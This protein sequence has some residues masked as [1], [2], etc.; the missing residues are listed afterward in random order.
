MLQKRTPGAPLSE[1]ELEQRRAAARAR[2]ENASAGAAG[3]ALAAGGLATAFGAWRRNTASAELQAGKVRAE[4]KLRG[5]EAAV[6]AHAGKMRDLDQSLSRPFPLR[7]YARHLSRK[8]GELDRR[9]EDFE[10]GRGKLPDPRK[11]FAEVREGFAR[12][13]ERMFT[14][15]MAAQRAKP[16]KGKQFIAGSGKTRVPQRLQG[17]KEERVLDGWFDAVSAGRRTPLVF[18]TAPDIEEMRREIRADLP[19][20]QAAFAAGIRARGER[21]A[22]RARAEG[23]GAARGVLRRFPAMTRGRVAAIAG[24]GALAGAGASWGR[25]GQVEKL[26]K[27][28]TWRTLRAAMRSS[29]LRASERG[30]KEQLASTAAGMR[31]DWAARQYGSATPGVTWTA[32]VKRAAGDALT[33]REAAAAD[34]LRAFAQER[35][36][37]FRALFRGIPYHAVAKNK[38]PTTPG[39]IYETKHV[40]SA[41]RRPSTTSQFIN[42]RPDE[43]LLVFRGGR[44]ARLRGAIKQDRGL[45]GHEDEVVLPPGKWRVDRVQMA[46]APPVRF[47]GKTYRTD[48]SSPVQRI[49]L[50]PVEKLAK[51]TR[52]APVR[53]ALE[54]DAL[55]ADARGPRNAAEAEVGTYR[56]AH[57]RLHGL[58]IAI[59]TPRGRERIGWAKDG[60]VKW[61]AVM[62]AHYGYVKGTVGA[63]GDHVDVYLMPE[64]MDPTRPVFV[65][66]Q[67]KL[68]SRAFDEVKVILGAADEAEALKVYDAGFNDGSGPQRRRATL[69]MSL[70]EFKDWLKG[71]TGGLAKAVSPVLARWARRSKVNPGAIAALYPR[72]VTERMLP[73]GSPL[74]AVTL[75][76]QGNRRAVLAQH[77]QSA[78]RAN[79][80]M[81]GRV[82]RH[83]LWHAADLPR[84][85]PLGE[86]GP[87]VAAWRRDRWIPPHAAGP[88]YPTDTAR[89]GEALAEVFSVVAGRDS[90]SRK[91]AA[92]IGA[93]YPVLT[94]AVRREA[95][96]HGFLHKAAPLA[97]VEPTEPTEP[98]DDGAWGRVEPDDDAPFTPVTAP[99][100]ATEDTIAAALARLFRGWLRNPRDVGNP[101]TVAEALRPVQDAFKAG[102]TVPPGG[103]QAV[104]TAGGSGRGNT[105][106]VSFDARNPRVEQHLREYSLG[107]IREISD[108]SRQAIRGALTAASIS[109]APVEQ[110]ARWIRESIGLTDAQAGWVRSFRWQLE[111]LD[112]RALGRE[113][114]DKRF[115]RTIQRAIETGTPIPPEKIDQM[116]EAYQR[117]TLAYRATTIARTE[118]I[119]AANLGSLASVRAMLDAHPELTVEKIWIATKDDRTRD[120]H[121]QLDGKVVEGLDAPFLVTNAKGEQVAIRWPHDPTAPAE[122]LIN[123]RCT[124]GF[125]VKPRQAVRFVAEAA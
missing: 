96:R 54:L 100:Q 48:R 71:Q 120:T 75:H 64:A 9:W 114:R 121:R 85:R 76:Q 74:A 19:K 31:P 99:T 20:H 42:A 84:Q 51:R 77:G 88:E 80:P 32:N 119:R 124:L 18:P 35:A 105:L 66:E 57:L 29:G 103:V 101:D 97:K 37:P 109:G 123:C 70:P 6:T 50:S 63:D 92:R 107:L 15:R 7:A 125:R 17:A 44:G 8:I 49:Y 36:R 81:A 118:A 41:T 25:A 58:E 40:L 55:A 16:P 21:E 69:R 26:A 78:L 79:D 91:L 94:R 60:S 2:W 46:P 82:R 73:T 13:R 102:A 14:L 24:L 106:L 95:L 56:K 86:R 62:P 3:G 83:E 113:L 28:A 59:E 27:G 68:P 47:R 33:E 61:R 65:V 104:E 117:R 39:A 67:V 30:F 52:G 5:A 110:Q 98:P 122:L 11:S 93:R 38:V 112:A 22:A 1:A 116:V 87:L 12:Q 53:T 23:F 90:R 43:Q 72:G 34:N 111:N 4:G 10:A 108:S 45:H 115:D 89:R